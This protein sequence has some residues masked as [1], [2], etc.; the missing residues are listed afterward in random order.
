M[1][2]VE[3]HRP[4]LGSWP[5]SA[6]VAGV[7]VLVLAVLYAAQAAYDWATRVPVG[8]SV[9]HR[10]LDDGTEFLLKHPCDAHS[11][12]ETLEASETATTVTV[13]YRGGSRSGFCPAVGCVD[14][15][16]S[17]G[18][19]PSTVPPDSCLLSVR[20]ESPLGDR[21]VIDAA[22]GLEVEAVG[23]SGTSSGQ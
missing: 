5:R 9:A 23:P 22:T 20:L 13:T 16:V 17:G 14:P 2:H 10:Q 3:T 1:P 21:T 18:G 12:G 7:I 11:K 4:G 8:E 19:D 15:V 6:R